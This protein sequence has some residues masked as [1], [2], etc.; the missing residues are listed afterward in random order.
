[1]SEFDKVQQVLHRSNPTTNTFGSTN[2]NDKILIS[3]ESTIQQQLIHLFVQ[4]RS[5][6]K[7]ILTRDRENAF[8]HNLRNNPDY[9]IIQNKPGCKT[10]HPFAG[11]TDAEIYKMLCALPRTGGISSGLNLLLKQFAKLLVLDENLI[12]VLVSDGCSLNVFEDRLDL[13]MRRNLLNETTR[14]TFQNRLESYISYFEDLEVLLND[15]LDF[16]GNMIHTTGFRT[17]HSIATDIRNRK[18]LI[19]VFDNDMR[20]VSG[21]DKM[22]L[23]LLS[24]DLE[25]SLKNSEINYSFVIDDLNYQYVRPFEWVHSQTKASVLM[26]LESIADYYTNPKYSQLV[27]S[28]FEIY[29]VFAHRNQNM[30]IFWSES[31]GRA[32]IVEYNYSNSNTVTTKYPLFPVANG[33]FGTQQYTEVSGFHYVDKNIHPDYEI[34]NLNN[35]ELFYF[36]KSQ[37]RI[38]QHSLVL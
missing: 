8:W 37:N 15:L 33:L 34:R 9:V 10:Y 7:I 19:F 32:R 12:E 28:N 4:N 20:S 22:L 17:A 36:V 23:S 14:N 29:M 3:G 11:H 38:S 6:G 27:R 21:Y 16:T 24:G 13:L 26:N 2:S 5:G 18:N 31:F 1:M 30:S 35:N 25:F